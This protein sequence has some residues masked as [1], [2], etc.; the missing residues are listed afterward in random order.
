MKKPDIGALNSLYFDGDSADQDVFAEMRSNVLLVSGEHYTK[1]S[2]N[3]YRRIRDSKELSQEQK[4]R[5]VK[6]HT[7]KI[8]QLYANNILAP[9]PGVGFTPKDEDSIHDQKVAEMHH[10][11]WQDAVH[12]YNIMDKKDDWVD[13]F[14][15]IGEVHV[16]IFYDPS[17]GKVKGYEAQFDETTG[18]EAIDEMGQQ[19]ADE[20]K[21]VFE[22]AFVFEEIYGF[23]LLRPPECKDLR[24]AEWLC[25]RKMVNRN[26]LKR[27]FKHDEEKADFI[28]SD[29]DDTYVI[30]DG[31]KGG[32]KKSTK[33]VMLR[34]YY[35][36]P[37]QLFPEGYFYITTKEGI[38]AEGPLPGGFFPIVS[39]QFDKI[40]TTPRGRSPV[41]VMR[42]YQA[43]I[44]RTASKIAEHQI[45]LGDDKLLIQNGSKVSAGAQLPGIRSVSYTG[46]KP[47]VLLGRAGDQYLA[48][49][50]SQIQEMYAVLMVAE[51]S[52][53]TQEN[54][55]LD[56]YALLFQSAR[57]KKKFQRYISKIEK[58][59]IEITELYLNLAKIHFPDDQIIMAAGKKEQINIPE[60][61]QYDNT[62]Y[63]VNIEA[64]SDDI[65]TKLGKQ[66]VMNNTLQYVGNKLSPEDIG[67]LMRQ[68]PFANFDESFE[69]F[70]L[71]Y[72]KSVNDILSLDRGEKPPV[73][74]YDD[75]K[76]CIKRL[77]TRMS[78]PDFQ[79]IDPMI[80]QN[81]AQ[82]IKVHEEFE[83]KN[84]LAIQRAQQGFIPTGGA[85][86]AV[87]FYVNAPNSTG[88]VKQQKAK[89]PYQ[90]IDW[91]LKQMESQGVTQEA[92][93]SMTQG[94]QASISEMILG[95]QAPGQSGVG[96]EQMAPAMPQ[97]FAMGM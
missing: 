75:H 67:K 51:D 60:F 44:N 24:E 84:A 21:P 89:V 25:I 30:F 40:Q 66:I 62:C 41:K 86:I 19:I 42:P 49:M 18:M 97:P 34:E 38:L 23:N 71:N 31:V 7:R 87:D 74:Q 27:K 65:E 2:A 61:R 6:N 94:N 53:P 77:T 80:Q 8:C 50:N 52:E 15:Q 72:D 59:L 36:R 26:E 16:K 95:A 17:L 39:A 90:A 92:L 73:N 63:E 22:G 69:D 37:S 29:S 10:S 56:P 93:M 54:G 82:K 11:V 28:V 64:Q 33:Q 48:Y 78:K 47:E 5:L 79:F 55:Q 83:A 9:N 14:V 88:G 57:R 3:F 81:Y 58:F 43:E 76:Y 85:L 45:T 70:T 4:L 32:Y 13:S 12:R 46:A 96:P 91:L 1:R 68:M 20:S 35:Y